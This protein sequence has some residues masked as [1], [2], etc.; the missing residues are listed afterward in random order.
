MKHF[1]HG[2]EISFLNIL[3]ASPAPFYFLSELRGW[4]AKGG[5]ERL[6]D[7]TAIIRSENDPSQTAKRN[8]GFL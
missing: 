5:E 6:E 8:E 2:V 1:K 7:K 4:P 3:I